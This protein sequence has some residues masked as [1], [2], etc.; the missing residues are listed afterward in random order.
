[1][2]LQE[3]NYMPVSDVTSSSAVNAYYT[4]PPQKLPSPATQN[5]VA[6]DNVTISQQAQQLSGNIDASIQ[7]VVVG[8]SSVAS[9]T[10]NAMA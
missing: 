8:A 6:T 10:F 9:N 2:E 7:A 4:P 5:A 1:L 3:V